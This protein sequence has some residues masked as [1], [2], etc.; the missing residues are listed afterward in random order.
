MSGILPEITKVLKS[1]NPKLVCKSLPVKLWHH[2]AALFLD[3]I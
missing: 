2:C 1:T 3:T